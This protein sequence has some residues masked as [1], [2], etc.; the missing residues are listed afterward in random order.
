MTEIKPFSAVVFN[1]EKIKKME[2]VVCPPYDVISEADQE[3]YRDQSRHNFI[4]VLL[5][6]D[7][8]GDEKYRKAAQRFRDWFKQGILTRDEKPAVYFYS[9][10][11]KL[12]GET[13][14][15]N[16][17]ISMMRLKEG[18]SSALGHEHTRID[19]VEDRFRL[20]SEVRGNLSP[21]FV[22]FRDQKRIIQRMR[23]R[24]EEKSPFIDLADDD[25]NRHQLWR[26]TES[27][28][29]SLIE[30][31]MKEES[32]FIAD[33][34]HRYEVACAWRDKMQQTLGGGTGDESFNYVLTYFTDTASRGLKIFPI[35]RLFR[36]G[37]SFDMESFKQRLTEYFYVEEIKDSR[38]F[39][40]LMEKGGL[41]EHLIGVYRDR[42]FHI[43]RLK[44]LKLVDRV[45]TDKPREYRA[46]D[47][48]ILN[49]VVLQE[50]LG[51]H[52]QKKEEVTFYHS[53][54]ELMEKVDNDPEYMA[55]FLN[56][57]KIE[58]ILA[59]ALKGEKMPPKSTYFY[60]K[61]LS[62]LLVHKF[63][64]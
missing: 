59:V 22:V 52:P 6:N 15:R 12:R 3:R 25:A 50:V 39:F 55:F 7:A 19:A 60:P 46:L 24:V 64:E 9:Q 13:K 37:S 8:G 18:T 51:A 14:T 29:I 54:K 16:G 45:I 34:H 33:G 11:Y 38:R 32:I 53:E 49:Y 27:R 17:F 58:Q 42:K 57:V 23:A 2:E 47:V 43:L 56:P 5:N 10:H 40:F 62:G 28:D 44:N 31:A 41:T 26:I 21:I 4:H 1:T 63:E 35:H 48:A 61:V 20:T 36:C 30:A